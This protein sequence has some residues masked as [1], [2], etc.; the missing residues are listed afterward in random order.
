MLLDENDSKVLHNSIN[1]NKSLYVEISSF[2]TCSKGADNARPP[3]HHKRSRLVGS[4]KR[5]VRFA[6]EVLQ[7]TQ[8][9]IGKKVRY[10]Q[11]L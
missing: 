8:M 9:P 6:V 5:L 11:W 3:Y 2:L 10:S 1:R 4:C 7:F